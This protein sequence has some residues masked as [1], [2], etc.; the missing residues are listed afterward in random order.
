MQMKAATL[1]N[2][3][4]GTDIQGRSEEK[5]ESGGRK[6]APGERGRHIKERLKMRLKAETPYFLNLKKYFDFDHFL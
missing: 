6:E 2:R 5:E 3:V 1:I 4:F